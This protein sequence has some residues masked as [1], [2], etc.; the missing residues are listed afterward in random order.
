MASQ[1]GILHVFRHRIFRALWIASLISNVGAMIQLVGAAWMMTLLTPSQSMVAL[2]QASVTMPMMLGALPAGVLADNYDRRNVML[3]AQVFMFVTSV[4]LTVLAFAGLLTPWLLLAFTFLIGCGMALHNP[5]WQASF[6]DLVPKQDIPSAVASNAMGMNVTRSVGPA[7][8]GAIVAVA[9][10]AVAFAINAV[11]YI[12]I[13]IALLR[14][15][16]KADERLLPRERYFGALAS[17]LRYFFLS[18]NLI[19]C[20]ARG[21]VFGFAAI[22]MQALLPLVARDKL[23]ADAFVFGVL[24]G[25]FGLGAVIGA[26][27]GGKIRARFNNETICRGGFLIFGATCLLVALSGN[28][29]LTGL[30]ICVSGAAWINLMSLINMTVQLSSPRW[31]IGRSIA[32]F[33]TF[34]F[35]GM[36]LGSWAWG[37]VAEAQ[38]L[39]TAFVLCAIVLA[40]GALAGLRWPLPQHGTLDLDPANRFHAPAV[41]LELNPQSGPIKILV[42]FDIAKSDVPEFLRLMAERRRI[43]VRDGA[44]QWSL[45]RDLARPEV[46]IECYR[47]PTWTDYVR[48]NDRRTISDDANTLR[49]FQINRTGSNPVV[50]R[51]IERHPTATQD[52]PLVE[53]LPEAMH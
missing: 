12:A 2:V 52:R 31:V 8:G 17:G 48:H 21:F 30:T 13:I 3:V 23:E 47:F 20:N 53:Q 38:G 19:S 42:E 33:M 35:G 36:T 26:L 9:G 1:T 51:M 24:L 28:V 25:A 4:L 14:W 50:H 37:A 7:A 49:L 32:L 5:S 22:A 27:N 29:V 39:E 6:S 16:P 18:P 15:R 10:A 44:R 46:W 43:H 45:S 41:E 11:T 40:A 34:I